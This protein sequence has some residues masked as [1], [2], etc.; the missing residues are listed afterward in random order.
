MADTMRQLDSEEL[1]LVIAQSAA[2]M[3][4]DVCAPIRN[5]NRHFKIRSEY[6][7]SYSVPIN[8]FSYARGECLGSK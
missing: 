6:V 3:G 7:D 8:S 2:D 4:A 5:S 1:K